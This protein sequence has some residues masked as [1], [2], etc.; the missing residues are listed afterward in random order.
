MTVSIIGKRKDVI[1]LQNALMNSQID[2]IFPLIEKEDNLFSSDF[3]EAIVKIVL[4]LASEISSCIESFAKKKKHDITAKIENGKIELT[5]TN[6][7][8]EEY[9]ELFELLCESRVERES[10]KSSSNT[11]EDRENEA[12]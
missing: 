2:V 6:A 7:T 4:S 5:M 8:N 12:Q 3:L 11:T 1:E 9:K 10:R